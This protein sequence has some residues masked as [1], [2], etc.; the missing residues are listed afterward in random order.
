V[1]GVLV[2]AIV[3]G[4]WIRLPYYTISPGG[5]L[6]VDQR[7]RIDG[8]RTYRPEGDVLLLYVRE[9][10]RVNVWRY[11]QAKLDS[12]IDIFPEKEITGG[13]PPE[14][15]RIQAQA[16]MVNSQMSAKKVALEAVGYRV[17]VEP[18][19]VVQG[20]LPSAPAAKVLRTGDVVL[21]IDGADV[22]QPGDLGTGVRTHEPGETVTLRI[23]RDGRERTVRVATSRN[24][25]G[26]AQ[27][28]VLVAG[29]YDFPVDISIDTSDIGG[30]SAG[31]AMTLAII[32]ELTPGNLTGGKRV[33][34][35]GTIAADAKVG[36]IG[37]IEQKTVAAKAAHAQ[38]FLVPKCT[39]E[40]ATAKR[41]CEHDL[42]RAR[43]RAGD[44][45]VVPV[46]SLDEALRALQKAGGT[47]ITKQAD[48][49]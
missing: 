20:V 22:K 17:P 19:A 14:E 8:A 10:A 13:Q 27:I 9:R 45:P 38:L 18:G 48:A 21:A 28:G 5:D 40:N 31:L 3:A 41:E 34:V 4:F 33:A 12:E 44:L 16:D 25:D 29:S 46:A 15:L 11:L 47:P 43:D 2:V 24:K 37:G 32:D 6:P 36:E 23:R 30:P 49:A 42:A 39:D 7:V 35:T 26:D 1:A